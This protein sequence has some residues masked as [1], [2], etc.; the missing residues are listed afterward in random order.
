MSTFTFVTSQIPTLVWGRLFP[1]ADPILSIADMANE[2]GADSGTIV[3]CMGSLQKA[4]FMIAKPDDEKG[5][6]FSD[7][8]VKEGPMEFLSAQGS[9]GRDALTG[10]I[11]VHMH[12]FVVDSDGMAHGGHFIPGQSRVMA[13]CEVTLLTGPGITIRRRFDPVAGTAVLQPQPRILADSP[14]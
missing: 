2:I 10:E 14:A 6:R 1:G 7:P 4:T 5:W 11:V 9:W 3:Q 12:G 8:I 13:T